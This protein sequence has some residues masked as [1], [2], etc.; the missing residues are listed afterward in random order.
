M[1]NTEM[2]AQKAIDE[3][4]AMCEQAVKELDFLTGHI[5]NDPYDLRFLNDKG[6]RMCPHNFNIIDC[7]VLDDN[8]CPGENC[9]VWR[10]Y[11]NERDGE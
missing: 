7:H 4:E 3:I 2:R 9:G 8:L 11:M 10:D 6:C 1:T 5:K